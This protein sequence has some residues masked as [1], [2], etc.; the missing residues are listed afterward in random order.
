MLSALSES[1]S[2]GGTRRD[3]SRTERERIPLITL[4]MGGDAELMEYMGLYDGVPRKER[5]FDKH[6]AELQQTINEY[7]ALT[8]KMVFPNS[9]AE[10]MKWEAERK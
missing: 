6:M 9:Y 2:A 8:D 10:W 4:A 3:L 5:A 7:K 1:M